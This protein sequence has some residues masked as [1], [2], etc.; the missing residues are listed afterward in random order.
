MTSGQTRGRASTLDRVTTEWPAG[1]SEQAG[2][3]VVSTEPTRRTAGW[4]L[5]SGHAA[6]RSQ[7][8]KILSAAGDALDRTSLSVRP[9]PLLTLRRAVPEVKAKP[10]SSDD[11]RVQELA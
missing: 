4:G 11:R 9:V 3:V 6:R 2:Q 5:R 1:S 8:P 10:N 7:R